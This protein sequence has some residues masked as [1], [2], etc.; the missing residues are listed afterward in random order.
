MTPSRRPAVTKEFNSER[1]ATYLSTGGSDGSTDL[2][3][4]RRFP[5]FL[6]VFAPSSTPFWPPTSGEEAIPPIASASDRVTAAGSA[7]DDGSG[8]A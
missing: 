1:C 6:G 5:E 2:D 3:L 7:E 8:E 4:S